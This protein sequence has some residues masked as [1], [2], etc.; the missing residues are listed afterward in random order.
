MNI[1]D[2]IL[3]DLKSGENI[4]LYATV[5][6]ALVVAIM[7]LFGVAK[8]GL[9]DS[10]GLVILALF[11]TA[12]LGNRYKLEDI[13]EKTGKNHTSNRILTKFPD[14]FDDD[15]KHASEIW[16][17][18]V[19]GSAI[20]K[21]K[22]RGILEDKLRK[23]NVT[24][25]VLL[26]DP[27]GTACGMSAARRPGKFSELSV[28]RSQS[29]ILANLDDLCELQTIS[30]SKL[31]IRVIDDPL[32]FACNVLDPD[33]HNG[34]IYFHR[35]SYQVGI[36]PKFVYTPANQEWFDFIKKEVRSLWNRGVEWEK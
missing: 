34:A 32:M 6:V 18:D 22:Y 19:N 35:Y 27:N 23:D 25:K 13:Q 29:N 10:V 3:N 30:P 16:I 7:N 2:R 8:A 1:F 28:K 17:I 36:I 15:F 26:I 4:D 11:A 33:S 9:L 24:V 14:Q 20:L 12:L 5:V 31:K 21:H